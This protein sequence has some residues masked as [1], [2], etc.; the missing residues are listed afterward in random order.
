MIYILFI[1]VLTIIVIDFFILGGDILSPSF[2]ACDMF[3]ISIFVNLLN[4]NRWG[5][6]YSLKA[7]T[8]IIMGLLSMILGEYIFRMIDNRSSIYKSRADHIK[9]KYY[10]PYYLSCT[11]TILIIIIS[12]SCLIIDLKIMSNIT[13]YIQIFSSLRYARSLLTSG[14]FKKGI[15]GRVVFVLNKSICFIEIYVFLYN[16]VLADTKNNYANIIPIIL[17]LIEAV[18][19]TGRVEFMRVITYSLFVFIQF[20]IKKTKNLYEQV[21]KIFL[22]AFCALIIFLIIFT[23]LGRLIGKGRYNTAIDVIY[24]YTGSSIYLFNKYISNPKYTSNKYFGEHTLYGIYNALHYIFP[25]IKHISN[26]ALEMGYIPNWYSNLY[27]A[28]RR[29]YQD[30]GFCGL[31]IIPMFLGLF[32]AKLETKAKSAKNCDWKCIFYAYSIYP[33]IEIAIEDRFLVNYLSFS[34][35]FQIAIL[36]VVYLFVTK[37]NFR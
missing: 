31:I 18:L 25:T 29:Y 9:T 13:G 2:L 10:H 30:F 32:Y 35:M 20:Y 33:V 34:N 21:K 19:S 22:S 37:V 4:T 14:I 7:L 26:P 6:S 3:L 12:F 24:Y 23:F 11:S 36:Y 17:F 5:T 27:T 8:Y 15:V 16:K 28:F 1:L